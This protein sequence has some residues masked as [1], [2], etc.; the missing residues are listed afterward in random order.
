[1]VVVWWVEAT[2]PREVERD[3]PDGWRSAEIGAGQRHCWVEKGGG[4][5][6]FKGLGERV[7]GKW[8][9]VSGGAFASYPLDGGGRLWWWVGGGKKIWERGGKMKRNLKLMGTRFNFLVW[10]KFLG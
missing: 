7:E 3:W 10:F 9:V 4:K 5:K 8:P 2:K 1:V 6:S